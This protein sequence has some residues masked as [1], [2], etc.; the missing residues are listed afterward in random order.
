MTRTLHVLPNDAVG[1]LERS[2][3]LIAKLLQ[4]RGVEQEVLIL[5]PLGSNGISAEFS[6]L[7]LSVHSVPCAPGGTVAFL[8]RLLG[9]MRAHRAPVLLIHGCFGL[10]SAI[11]AV[12][13]ITGFRRVWVFIVNRPSV[14]SPGRWLRQLSAHGARLSV[15]GEIVISRYLRD[16]LTRVYLMP[17]S[18][19]H[20]HY[21]WREV[22]TIRQRAVRSERLP[23]SG[24]VF[25]CVARLDW[26][27]DHDTVIRAFAVVNARLG[28]ARLSIV[29]DG[30]ERERLE[31]LVVQVGVQGSVEFVGHSLDVPSLLAEMDIF[32]FATSET[33]GFGTVL[34]EAMAAGVPIIAPAVGPAPEILGDGSVGVL[35]PPRDVGAMA[36]AMIAL[37]GDHERRAQ[38]SARGLDWARE[39][40]TE[41]TA[42][43]RLL[44]L[45]YGGAV[46]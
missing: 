20:V 46:D 2:T 1:G 3:F 21:R 38:L 27:K 41:E 44:E 43:P 29:G 39:H 12:A 32:V 5:S 26:M 30:D 11:A 45:I 25:G 7:G 10:H 15:D 31:R 36:D 37:W 18:R 40:F 6:A 16:F 17:A 9:F 23:G 4:R 19:I 8:W 14:T 24:P 28:G 13:R 33:E 35:V 42:A 22:N 34:A